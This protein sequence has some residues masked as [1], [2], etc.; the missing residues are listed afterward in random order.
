MQLLQYYIGIENTYYFLSD[1]R[2]EIEQLMELMHQENKEILKLLLSNT[3]VDGVICVENTSTTLL[4]P[5]IF[6]NYCYGYLKEYGEIIKET[7]KFYELHMC[8]CLKGLLPLIDEIPADCIEAFSSPPV[9]DTTIKDGFS[10]C[11]SKAIIGGTCA[12][13]W[14][15]ETD[16]II[17][18]IE[19]EIKKAGKIEGLVLTSAGVMPPAADI[20]KIRKVRMY[21]KNFKL[22]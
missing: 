12:T 17:E 22:N 19:S 10:L 14:L 15:L 5:D 11:P 13:I 7:E 18:W 3:S 6:K 1:F 2:E 16:K 9:G 4:S 8:G 21:F 20:E